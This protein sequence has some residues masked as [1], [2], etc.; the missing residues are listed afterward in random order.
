MPEQYD[1]FTTNAGTAGYRL[2]YMDVKVGERH[3]CV[4]HSTREYTE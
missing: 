3:S 4:T 1:L 2:N